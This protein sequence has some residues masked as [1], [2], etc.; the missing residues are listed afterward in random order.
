MFGDDFKGLVGDLRS[1]KRGDVV[2][3]RIKSAL[4]SELADAQPILKSEM[5]T[6]WLRNP[7]LR[8]A[9]Q[10][11]SFTLKQLDIMRREIFQKLQSSDPAIKAEGAKMLLVYPPLLGAGGATTTAIKDIMLG[12]EDALDPDKFDDKFAESIIK[13]FGANKYML[14]QVAAGREDAGDLLIDV[15]APRI[16]IC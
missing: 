12:R 14:D 5:P 3:D 7:E 8:I 13:I 11:K 2:N 6:A 16:R 10:L 4:L 9:W 1:L 15:V